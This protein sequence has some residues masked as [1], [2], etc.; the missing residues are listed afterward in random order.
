[1]LAGLAGLTHVYGLFW[2]IVLVLL[3][4]WDRRP[5]RALLWLAVGALVP[6]LPYAAYVLS[7]LPEWRAQVSGYADRFGLLDPRFYLSNLVD[8]PHRYGP[9]LGSPGLGWLLRPGFW[10]LLVLVPASV[11]ALTRRAIRQHDPAARTIVVPTILLPV[12]FAL[13]LRLKLVNYTLTFQPVLAIALA[14]GILRALSW[15]PHKARLLAGVLALAVVAEGV[16]RLALLETTPATPYA[17]FIARVHRTIPAGARVVGLHNYWFGFEDTDYRSFVVP[18]AWMDPGG[19]PLAQG[20]DRLAPD[21]V[22]LDDRLRS[23]LTYDPRARAGFETW[24]STSRARLAD[25]VDDPTY[26]LMQIYVPDATRASAYTGPAI[27]E[28]GGKL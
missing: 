12:L 9:G 27:R 4:L 17:T 19:L 22:L 25:Q 23:Y 3:V 20:L 7:D 26:G 16:S 18:L 2:V 15:L 5:L 11:V 24:L 6:W 13:L 10:T 21:A 8:E 28:H 14:W 1:L